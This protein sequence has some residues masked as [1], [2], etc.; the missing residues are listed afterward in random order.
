MEAANL[1]NPTMNTA[2]ILSISLKEGV[3]RLDCKTDKILT[4]LLQ[5]HGMYIVCLRKCH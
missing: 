4:A 2:A 5:Q 3:S 1:W